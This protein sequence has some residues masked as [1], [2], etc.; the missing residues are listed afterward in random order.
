MTN[1]ARFA[2][3][4]EAVEQYPDLIPPPFDE[5]Y[6]ILGHEKFTA[7]FGYFGGQ[8]VYVPTLRKVFSD[9]IKRRAGELLRDRTHSVDE[10]AK[11]YG[12][13]SRYLRRVLSGDAREA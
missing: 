11:K 8:C 12:Y 1:Q 9:A 6:R 3:V 13:T 7:F 4:R 2:S 5:L 10:V